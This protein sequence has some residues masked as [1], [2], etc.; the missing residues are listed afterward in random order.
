MKKFL[1]VTAIVILIF[2]AILIILPFA[3]KG[4]IMSATKKAI[5]EN[6]N[7]KVEFADLGLSFI[8]NFPNVSVSIDSLSIAGINQFQNDTLLS[9]SDLRVTLDIMSVI[10]GSTYE[11]RKVNLDNARIKLRILEDGLANWDI[12]KSDTTQVD[13]TISEPSDFKVSLKKASINNGFLIYDDA[14]IPFYSRAEGIDLTLKGDLSEVISELDTKATVQRLLVRYDGVR[15]LNKATASLDSRIGVDL[16]NYKFTFPD[17][18]LNVNDLELLAEGFFAMPDEGYNMDIAFKALRNEFRSF[19]SLIPEVYAKDFNQLKTSGTL[20]FTGYVKGLYSD[21]TIPAFGINLDIADG[22]FQYPSL[23]GAVENINVKANIDNKTGDPDATIIDVPRF[24]IEM[25][26]NPFDA[27]MH[28]RTPVSDPYVD[29]TMK[30]KL[31]LDDVSKIYP[32]EEGDK[33]NGMVDADIAVKGNQ[34]SAESLDFAN[35]MA[36]GYVNVSNLEYHT[37]SLSDEL[38]ISSA[39]VELSPEVIKMPQMNAKIG[40]NDISANGN[41]F[42]YIAYAFDKGDLGGSF[43]LVSNYLNLNDLMSDTSEV[44]SDTTASQLSVIEVPKNVTFS[45]N[46]TFKR[47]I[48]GDLEATD[49]VGVMRIKD[50][51]LS[52]E[53]LRL[54]ALEGQLA[55]TGS[56]STKT[57]SVPVVDMAMNLQNISVKEAFRSFLTVRKLAPIAEQTEGKVSSNLSF[58]TQLDGA[59]MPIPTTLQGEGNLTSPAITINNV[60][61]FNRVADALKMDQ[62][63]KWS[64][65]K[66][67][68]SFNIEDGKVF[69]KPFDVKIGNINTSI[70]GWNSFDQTLEYTMAM[71]IPRST[72][73]GAANNVLENL[74]SKVNKAG[75]NFSLGETV[76]V[77]VLISGLVT[78]P[79]VSLDLGESAADLKQGLNEVVQQKKEEA[80]TKV[81][82]EAGKY[83]EE[84]NQKAQ[85]LIDEA[86]IKADKLMATAEQSAQKLRK[87]ADN[88]ANNLIS[89]GAKKGPI[90]KI[91]AEK[92]ADQVKKEADKKALSIISVAQKQSDEIMNAARQQADK[93]ISDAKSK[94]Q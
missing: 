94:T 79:K 33:L 35:F 6:I 81:K 34:S 66:I 24:H 56:Y 1:K 13:D 90:A 18:K 77:S 62:F 55:L 29:M 8:R 5:N 11:V 82:E 37:V 54:N 50:Q 71:E 23:P 73:G 32:L 15:Y 57:A 48:Y 31:N 46:S 69:V 85:K 80:I 27:V 60:N 30:G 87:E 36:Q 93:I 9:A 40:R 53:N 3:F 16:E 61:T 21:N 72:F 68:L 88:Q 51:V 19:L 52:L 67:N 38:S 89:E 63:K 41:I 2:L 45:I 43:N 25:M 91:A 78:D 26:G 20:A 42:N 44:E 76:P 65:N 58:T 17:A 83:I 12:V 75:A 74:V 22:R 84:A 64:V 47:I 39:R 59:M 49:A 10:R 70:A 7:A 28:V 86:Q 4:K 92:A 14:S